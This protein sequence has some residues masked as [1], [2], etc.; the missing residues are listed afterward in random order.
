DGVQLGHDVLADPVVDHPL[1]LEHRLLGGVEGG[2]VVLEVLDQGAGL[3]TFVEDLRLALVDL[4]TAGHACAFS[5]DE[6]LAGRGDEK[7]ARLNPSRADPTQGVS[8]HLRLAEISGCGTRA[9]TSPPCRLSIATARRAGYVIARRA[10]LQ[11]GSPGTPW[12]PLT[13]VNVASRSVS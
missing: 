7:R 4:L 5:G 6:G 8:L 9:Q 10:R 13:T 12:P 1:A 11:R 2:G 3:G